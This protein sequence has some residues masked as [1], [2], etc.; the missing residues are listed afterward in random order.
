ME[1]FD[2]DQLRRNVI[3][4]A[5]RLSS[6]G[7]SMG[8]SGNVSVRIDESRFLITPTALPYDSLELQD[9]CLVDINHP[10]VQQGLRKPSSETPMHTAVYLARPDIHAL[11]HTH[12]LYATA[13]A[14]AGKPVPAVH[15]VVAT[16]GN[17]IPVV[18]Y[19]TYGSPELADAVMQTFRTGL[20]VLLQNHG[21]LAAGKTLQE[22]FYH[23]TTIEYLAHLS[24]VAQS[25]GGPTLL[26]A[27]EL[28]TVRE[29]FK[30]YN[31][32]KL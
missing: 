32:N 6:E 25:L 30:G 12:S 5:Q 3:E 14:C 17:E 19:R 4:F 27:A 13:F 20:G 23:A 26:S 22:A 18:P 9:V 1:N 31:Q 21:V 28:D 11:V 2:E 15:Y 10:E 29:K 7:L 8:T 24:F 16:M